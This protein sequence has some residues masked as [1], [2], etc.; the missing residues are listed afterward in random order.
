[1]PES[2]STHAEHRERIRVRHKS[3][4]AHGHLKELPIEGLAHERETRP[5]PVPSQLARFSQHAQS[6]HAGHY[7][8]PT[9]ALLRRL[10]DMS[11]YRRR[12]RTGVRRTRLVLAHSMPGRRL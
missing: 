5:R 8:E 12:R 2:T 3:P 9:G 10:S 7:I 4:A 11:D 6:V 1:M